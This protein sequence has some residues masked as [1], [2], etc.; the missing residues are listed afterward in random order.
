MASVC[1]THV[2]Q[3][4]INL[5]LISPICVISITVLIFKQL[6]TVNFAVFCLIWVETTCEDEIDCY[7]FNYSS[8]HG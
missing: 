1:Q 4:Y 7:S 5:N 8:L 6:A 2:H 3:L